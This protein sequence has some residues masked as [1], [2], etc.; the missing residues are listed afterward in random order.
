MYK[1]IH[2]TVYNS[3]GISSI[4]SKQVVFATGV[5][6]IKEIIYVC[7]MLNSVATSGTTQMSTPA[8]DLNPT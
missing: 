1:N 8:Q 4:S 6:W 7:R 2:V 3:T 5:I